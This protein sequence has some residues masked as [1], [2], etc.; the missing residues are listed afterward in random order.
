VDVLKVWGTRIIE[1][2]K[3]SKRVNKW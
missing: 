3:H 2:Y 1:L